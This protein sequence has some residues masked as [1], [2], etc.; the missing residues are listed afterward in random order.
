MQN[1]LAYQLLGAYNGEVL[2]QREYDDQLEYDFAL[3]DN[4]RD[5]KTFTLWPPDELG[6]QPPVSNHSACKCLSIEARA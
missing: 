5:D 3:G 1:L 4:V 2:V 6:T